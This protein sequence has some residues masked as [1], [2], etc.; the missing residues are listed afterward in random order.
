MNTCTCNCIDTHW[1]LSHFNW[2]P[3]DSACPGA[4]CLQCCRLDDCSSA[5]L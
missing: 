3:K 4:V 1:L 2:A 5:T